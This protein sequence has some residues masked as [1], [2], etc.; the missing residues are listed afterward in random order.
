MNLFTWSNINS[1]MC[2]FHSYKSGEN[3]V[4]LAPEKI[5]YTGSWKAFVWY[6]HKGGRLVYAFHAKHNL[7][8]VSTL[9]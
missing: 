2:G 8:Q 6:I 3:W 1:Y 7:K 4:E 9:T 5:K